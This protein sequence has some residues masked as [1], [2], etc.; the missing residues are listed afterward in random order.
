MQAIASHLHACGTTVP[1]VGDGA[2][3]PQ[4]LDPWW[5]ELKLKVCINQTV[6]QENE[7]K[8]QMV[9]LFNEVAAVDQNITKTLTE[10]FA[11]R[12]RIEGVGRVKAMQETGLSEHKMGLLPIRRKYLALAEKS[13]LLQD[14]PHVC[15]VRILEVFGNHFG[16]P[17][18]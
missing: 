3:P 12:R 6:A 17:G 1:S 4:M 11:P 7:Y 14:F 13:A 15:F 2:L 10:I 18:R 16:L 9:Q 5:T 8:E